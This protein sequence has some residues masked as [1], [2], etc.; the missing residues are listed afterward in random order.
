VS[1]SRTILVIDDDPHILSTVRDVLALDL[2]QVFTAADG[3]EGLS[4]YERVQPDLVLSDIMLPDILGHD[5]CRTIKQKNPNQ[6][7]VFMSGLSDELDQVVGLELGADD[8]L[9]KP[10]TIPFFRSKIRSLLR[11]LKPT[12]AVP[13]NPEHPLPLCLGELEIDSAA[14]KAYLAGQELNLTHKEFSV[15]AWMAAHPG[16]LFTRQQLLEQL[17]PDDL[18]V[19]D[20]AVDALIRRLRE[21]LTDP[22]AEP[23]FIETVRGM[24]YRFKLA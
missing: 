24:G 7:F 22:V 23:H 3:R 13:L 19:N 8:Y 21:K 12:S 11:R 17:W 2:Y 6:L 18:D 5:L 1:A 15:L 9:V 10:F 14:Y 4:L 16:Q 20:R